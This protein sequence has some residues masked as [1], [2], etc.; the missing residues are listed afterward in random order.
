MRLALHRSIAFWSGILVMGFFGWAWWDSYRHDSWYTTRHF[1]GSNAAGAVSLALY[2]VN[3]S[4]WSGRRDI[5]PSDLP[6]P[7]FTKLEFISDEPDISG[8][9]SSIP[10]SGER[11]R[12]MLSGARGGVYRI[13]NLPHWLILLVVAIPWFALLAWRVRRHRRIPQA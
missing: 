4:P 7:A 3:M 1:S 8:S 9:V 13:L 5:A 6:R 11:V 2:Q 12:I 10:H